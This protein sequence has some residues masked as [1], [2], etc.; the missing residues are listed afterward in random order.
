MKKA[1]IEMRNEKKKQIYMVKSVL[2][3][4]FSGYP[5]YTIKHVVL[6]IIFLSK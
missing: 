3:R 5:D 6:Y 1:L 4:V 2:I